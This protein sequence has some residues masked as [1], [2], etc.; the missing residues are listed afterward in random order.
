MGL[1]YSIR[2][3]NEQKK[4]ERLERERQSMIQDFQV[5]QQAADQN[6]KSALYQ[7]GRYYATGIPNFLAAD[8]QK[9][10]E[11][12][13]RAA[14]KASDYVNGHFGSAAAA[15]S[16]ASCL[17]HGTGTNPDY[18]KAAGI[19][20]TLN[21]EGYLSIDDLA[22][23][24]GNIRSF[25]KEA[26]QQN[27]HDSH[28][29]YQYA[30]TMAVIPLRNDTPSIKQEGIRLMQQAAEMGYADA[31]NVLSV[32]MKGSDPSIAE[33]LLYESAEKGSATAQFRIGMLHY[34]KQEF[35]ESLEWFEKAGES[36]HASAQRQ[37]GIVRF[38]Y[39]EDEQA[40]KWMLHAIE[41]RED[42]EYYPNTVCYLVLGDILRDRGG[43]ENWEKALSYYEIGARAEECASDE[44]RRS[45]GERSCIVSYK[46]LKPALRTLI[47]IGGK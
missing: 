6:S 28:A 9:A 43:R 34:Q 38:K 2:Q 13:V 41:W 3:K 12:Y 26:Y 4:A 44:L 22:R 27:S 46:K 42:P 15:S 45:L 33:K 21:Q 32:L 20:S 23:H 14:Q 25:A 37:A 40:E 18:V 35:R 7:L 47:E 16:A 31:F 36:G 30:Y 29:L 39:N 8:P 17:M 24:F 19:F 5:Q 10:F 1:F 11:L